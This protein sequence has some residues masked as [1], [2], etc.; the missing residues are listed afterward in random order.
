MEAAA[1]RLGV[2]IVRV[3]VHD[4]AEIEP[5]ISAFA[6]AP[7]GGLLLTGS[8]PRVYFEASRLALHYRLPLMYGPSTPSNIVTE[9]REGVLMYH[10]S[11]FLAALAQ[12]AGSGAGTSMG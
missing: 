4:T 8:A 7:D 6:A 10:G 11:D 1:A 9:A 3:P 5:A 12:I 2:T